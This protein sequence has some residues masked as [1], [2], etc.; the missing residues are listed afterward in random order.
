MKG[1]DYAIIYRPSNIFPRNTVVKVLEIVGDKVYVQQFQRTK[2]SW[3]DRRV[4]KLIKLVTMGGAEHGEM[5]TKP[6]VVLDTMKLKD[7]SPL[8]WKYMGKR[9]YEIFGEEM[10]ERGVEGDWISKV[11]PPVVIGRFLDPNSDRG[12]DEHTMGFMAPW[13]PD[14]GVLYINEE[15]KNA[16]EVAA[17][18][19]SHILSFLS[20]DLAE[21]LGMPEL[22]AGLAEEESTQE[23]D[24]QRMREEIAV[25]E[26]IKDPTKREKK[27]TEL[28]LSLPTEV[29]AHTE[30]MRYMLYKMKEQA[31]KL[32]KMDDA[33]DEQQK[34]EK[35]IEIQRSSNEEYEDDI[36]DKMAPAYAKKRNLSDEQS[37]EIMKSFFRNM[38][39]YLA[40]PKRN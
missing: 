9:I 19:F 8:L 27:K 32:I 34:R 21:K 33:L 12:I 2:K 37:R 16:D 4:L 10:A 28:Y 20:A 31:V 38:D 22:A 1:G 36:I 25:L 14:K 35:I 3:V 30:Q 13:G 6:V 7:L 39:N 24:T 23:K 5:A 15:A 26:K 18:E 11:N 40:N 17:H 29:F